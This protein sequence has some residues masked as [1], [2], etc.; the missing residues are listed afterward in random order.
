MSEMLDGLPPRR[1]RK[2]QKRKRQISLKTVIQGGL[3]LFGALF[4]GLIGW[5]LYHANQ[6]KQAVPVAA[7]APA[8]E[9]K[10]RA[11]TRDESLG[12]DQGQSENLG[13]EAN[14]QG[15]SREGAA[16]PTAEAASTGEQPAP[17]AEKKTP[18][19]TTSKPMTQP[20][21]P[22]VP[23]A[24]PAAQTNQPNT[25]HAP[26]TAQPQT[27]AQA[28][29]TNA[30]PKAIRHV[31]QK[32]DTLFK[33]SRQYYGNNSGVARIARYNGFPADTQLSVGNVVMI[34][35]AP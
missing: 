13:Q 32:G 5:E 4:F 29:G 26:P 2:I 17:S 8:D 12:G 15:A 34:P 19:E 31:V 7:E 20:T 28:Q 18:Q 24:K 10:A 33:L 1:S 9:S 11:S 21:Q 22:A 16:A 27:G 14:Q 3:V 23:A 35:L 25:V 30:Q 6:V